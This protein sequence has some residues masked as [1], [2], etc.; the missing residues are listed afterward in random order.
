MAEDFP[1]RPSL[2][3]QVEQF[4]A[5]FGE[6]Q[7]NS[8]IVIEHPSGRNFHIQFF[9]NPETGVYNMPVS[10]DRRTKAESVPQLSLT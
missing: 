2:K 3:E 4:A 8:P 1:N 7:D 5:F 6:D 9:L 10:I